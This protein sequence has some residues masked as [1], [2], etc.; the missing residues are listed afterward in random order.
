MQVHF[1]PQACYLTNSFHK[2]SHVHACAHVQNVVS[3]GRRRGVRREHVLRNTPQ[4][5]CLVAVFRICIRIME[6]IKM[7]NVVSRAG[8]EPI[9]LVYRSSAL[10]ITPPT[11]PD[12]IILSRSSRLCGSLP[13]ASV[14]NTTLGYYK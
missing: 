4:L 13:E 11:V 14:Q 1:L 6:A 12:A 3:Q 7:R 5:G 10:T 8:I 2:Y 9:S